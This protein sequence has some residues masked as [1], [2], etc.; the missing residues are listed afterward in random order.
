MRSRPVLR[1]AAQILVAASVATATPLTAPSADEPVL[2][3]GLVLNF[4]ADLTSDSIDRGITQTAHRPGVTGT[5]ELQK[6][7]F[8]VSTEI[9]SVKPPTS[10]AAEVGGARVSGRRFPAL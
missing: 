8:Y 1:G 3:G 2:P 7:W 6:D 4:S 5:V 10:P 9:S